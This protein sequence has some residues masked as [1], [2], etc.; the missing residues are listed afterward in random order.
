LGNTVLQ[1][2]AD[3]SSPAQQVSCLRVNILDTRD[4]RTR[5]LYIPVLMATIRCTLCKVWHV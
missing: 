3:I 1:T 4:T 5:W 2:G